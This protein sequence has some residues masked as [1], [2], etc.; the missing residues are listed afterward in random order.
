[1]NKVAIQSIPYDNNSS[2]MRGAA[3]G[4]HAL[5][6]AFRSTSA[7]YF[8]QDGHDLE[9]HETHWYFHPIMDISNTASF[10]A[11]EAI[12]NQSQQL[13]ANGYRLISLGGDHSV[14]FPILKAY[15]NRFEGLQLLQIDAHGDL[16][17]DFEGNPFSH[18]SPFA[19]IMENGLVASLTQ[20]GNR[21]LTRHQ[22]E[23]AKRF[24]VRIIEMK[25][26]DVQKLPTFIGPLY[27]SLDLDALDPAFAPG[28]A[29]HEPGGL[30]TREVLKIIEH[31]SAP[32]VGADIVELNPDRD[33]HQMTAMVGAK[34]LKEL[35]AKVLL[36]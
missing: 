7:N 27:I 16:Y 14:S 36:S 25:D 9:A 31:I 4:P 3:K 30:S 20:I 11:H 18:A 13:L 28:V 34:F 29:H 8:T 17:D 22:R 2:Y 26:F 10:E 6:A 5:Q 12:L 33:I 21:T 32:V 19:R 1:M 23:Q 35:L 24:N 15:G